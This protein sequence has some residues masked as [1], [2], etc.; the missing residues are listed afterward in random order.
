MKLHKREIFT[1]KCCLR[2]IAVVAASPDWKAPDH[3]PHPTSGTILRAPADSVAPASSNNSVPQP[4][5]PTNS[6]IR[7]FT[8]KTFHMEPRSSGDQL[9]MTYDPLTGVRTAA[10]LG[11]FMVTV[12]G[13]ILYKAKYN[14]NRWTSKDRL[15]I[16]AYKKK[17]QERRHRRP[18]P[19]I[20]TAVRE[21]MLRPEFSLT[22]DLTATWVKSHPISGPDG[23][24]GATPSDV[25]RSVKTSR[26][27]MARKLSNGMQQMRQDSDGSGCLNGTLAATAHAIPSGG[28]TLHMLHGQGLV[29]RFELV[30]SQ[31]LNE[32]RLERTK[33]H[34]IPSIVFRDG[35]LQYD[36][37]PAVLKFSRIPPNLR[38]GS[39]DLRPAT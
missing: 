10:I 36:A 12:M 33:R 3:Q 1:D 9:Y 32:I 2:D 37:H 18:V 34:S 39:F 8:V 21:L 31:T 11:L 23:D 29:P 6:A 20:R 7:Y 15:F 24:T 38:H 5:P 28:G 27:A 30:A 17:L 14:R 25:Q 22:P 35:S 13:Y 26:E 16:E 19:D 4:Q